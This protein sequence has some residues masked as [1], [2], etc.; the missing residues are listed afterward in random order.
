MIAGIV[1]GSLVLVAIVAYVIYKYRLRVRPCA[2]S[3]AGGMGKR[4]AIQH[5]RWGMTRSLCCTVLAF[6]ALHA[7]S[8]TTLL[9]SLHSLLLC[10]DGLVLRLQSYMDSEIRAIMAQYMPLESQNEPLNR[11][12][13]SKPSHEGP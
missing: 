10:P 5:G 4:G 1:L 12:G 8:G 9:F 2:A 6:P 7:G 13:A 3:R 11:E